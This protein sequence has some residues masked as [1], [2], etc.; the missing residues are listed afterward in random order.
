[1]IITHHGGECFKLAH[2]DTTVAYNPPSKDSKLKGAK[3]G[4]DIALIS[5]NHPDMNGVEQVA[6]GERVPVSITGPGEYEIKDIFIRGFA[7]KS[8]Y[9]MKS[10]EKGLEHRINTV[11]FVKM[12]GID[13]LFLGAFSEEK[14]SPS[15]LEEIDNVDILFVP[16]GGE[17]VLSPASAHKLATQLDAKIVIPIHYDGVGEKDSLKLFLKESASEGVKE[18]EKFTVKKK[19][20]DQQSGEVVVLKS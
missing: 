18:I 16:V 9:D 12:E 14:L 19:D 10:A 13:L 20:I 2:G 1:M 11:Y 5:L 3:F 7:T 4:S 8:D 6:H 17:G 15:I